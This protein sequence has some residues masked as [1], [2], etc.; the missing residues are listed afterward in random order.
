MMPEKYKNSEGKILTIDLKFMDTPGAIAVYAIPH[1]HGIALVET[2]PGS[3]VPQLSKSLEK[4]GYDL[5]D[6]TDVLLTHI[7]LDHAGASGY[8]ANQ[9]ARI[10]VH[11]AGAPH[12]LN[13]DKLLASASRIYGDR[14]DDLWGEFL[15]VPED[16][17]SILVDGAIVEIE[18]LRF[19]VLDTPGHA[20]HHNAY[21]FRD[22]CFTGDVGGV[23]LQGTQFIR[24]PMPPP[25]FLLE[26]WRESLKKLKKEFARGGFTKIAPTHFGIFDDPGWHLDS[27]ELI[28][29]ETEQW[30]IEVMSKNPTIEKL[31]EKFLDWNQL[32]AQ[33]AGM[34]PD[35]LQAYELANPSWMSAAGIYRYW[36][37]VRNVDHDN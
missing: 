33:E 19:K 16:R 23:R 22:I 31:K 15:P 8:L 5:K 26:T 9:G 1:G 18:D 21:L 37:K 6:I 34:Q 17:L 13:P 27:L 35:I 2:G 36:H 4:L 14:M 29:D 10:H 28:L 7:H 32:S 30:I 3:T 20:N 12:L 25:E 11:Q 24:L